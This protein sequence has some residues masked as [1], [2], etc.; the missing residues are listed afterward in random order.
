[1][2]TTLEQAIKEHATLISLVS[3]DVC[4]NESML[5]MHNHCV[6]VKMPCSNYVDI[7]ILHKKT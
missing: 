4:S 2:I 1:M 5:L 3:Y 6:T 7:I